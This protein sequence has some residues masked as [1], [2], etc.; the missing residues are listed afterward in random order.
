MY[1]ASL[2][3]VVREIIPGD[4]VDQQDPTH[5]ELVSQMLHDV[6][7]FLEATYTCLIE[8]TRSILS[9]IPLGSHYLFVFNFL[10]GVQCKYC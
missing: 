9:C 4:E 10:S 2:K 6:I 5:Q 1:P 7:V 3:R 8:F